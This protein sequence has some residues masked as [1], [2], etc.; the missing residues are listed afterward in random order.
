MTMR[1]EIHKDHCG[2]K[3]TKYIHVYA[4]G[5][6]KRDI[7]DLEAFVKTCDKKSFTFAFFRALVLSRAR[8]NELN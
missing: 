8:A 7:C 4:H 2:I 1:E 6:I 3:L 5:H